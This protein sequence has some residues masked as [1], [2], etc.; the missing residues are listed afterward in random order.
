MGIISILNTA[1][2]TAKKNQSGQTN[3]NQILKEGIKWEDLPQSKYNNQEFSL[4]KYGIYEPFDGKI[5]AF[6]GL[7]IYIKQPSIEG[8]EEHLK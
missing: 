8:L 5:K 6:P 1:K 2:T 7:Y 3:I 4:H